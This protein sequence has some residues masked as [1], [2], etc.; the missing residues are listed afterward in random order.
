LLSSIRNAGGIGA[1]KKVNT[2]EKVE[3]P[4]ET[5]N[6]GGDDLAAALRAALT[7]RQGAVGGNSSSEEESDWE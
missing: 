6:S 4:V 5:D 2:E 1:L 7:K 3:T